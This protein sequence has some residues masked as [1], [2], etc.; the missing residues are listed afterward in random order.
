MAKAVSAYAAANKT[1]Y[2]LINKALSAPEP[3]L[4]NEALTSSEKPV[5]DQNTTPV[6][7]PVSDQ[8]ATTSGTAAVVSNNK[9]KS[10]LGPSSTTF[11]SPVR[12]LVFVASSNVWIV[13]YA[14]HRLNV[15]DAAIVLEAT[16][17][18]KP[19]CLQFLIA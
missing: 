13:L 7:V 12:F 10:L 15:Y 3:L 6:D 5:I 1:S 16:S 14:A 4:L 17:P 2:P 18:Y 9:L 8:F 11:T 19:L